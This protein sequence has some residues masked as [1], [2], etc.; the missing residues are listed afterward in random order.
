MS[1]VTN[2]RTEFRNIHISQII[3]YRLPPAGI[4]SILH[5]IS[6]AFLFLLLPFTLYLLEQSLVSED[7]YAHLRGFA[8]NWWM[9]LIILALSSAYLLHFL[10]GVRHL[11]MDSHV[12]LD[13]K[14]SN[15][16]SI[17]V[18]AATLLLSLAIALKLFGVF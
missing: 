18:L 10:A 6:G 1:E 17:G 9:K 12:G 8:S 14:S 16:T 11:A 5:R 13:K 2:R 7:T 4:I 15:H 3:K